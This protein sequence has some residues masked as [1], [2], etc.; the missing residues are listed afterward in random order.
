MLVKQPDGNIC[1]IRA[2]DL[3]RMLIIRPLPYLLFSSGVIKYMKI[4]KIDISKIRGR[5]QDSEIIDGKLVSVSG[6][7]DTIPS[8]ILVAEKLNE[9]IELLSTQPQE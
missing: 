5:Y 2:D 8:I 3:F 1:V 6:G 4:E 9:I 7:D